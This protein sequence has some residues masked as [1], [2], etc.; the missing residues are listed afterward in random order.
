MRKL[1]SYLIILFFSFSCV[2]AQ[3]QHVGALANFQFEGAASGNG[4]IAGLEIQNV[5]YLRIK[6]Q[7]FK[8][9]TNASFTLDKK[10]YR[11]Q[12][13]GAAR[14]SSMLRYDLPIQNKLFFIQGGVGFGGIAFPNTPGTAD[15]YVKYLVRPVVGGGIAVTRKDW[16]V[17]ADYQFLFKRE[18][19]AQGLPVKRGA[20]T[21]DGWSSGQRVG[22]AATIAIPSNPRWLILLNGAGGGYTYQRNPA[23]YGAAL[24]AVIHHFNAYEVSIGVGRK[25]GQ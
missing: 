22:I 3:P 16:S 10:V 24:G 9:A 4:T 25:Y 7:D 8:L 20:S 23:V 2:Q 18:L 5:E 14:V 12:F 17:V 15:G 6:G 21:L 19:Y 1:L 11:N 13:G